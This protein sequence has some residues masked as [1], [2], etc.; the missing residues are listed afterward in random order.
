M[1]SLPYING[2]WHGKKRNDPFVLDSKEPDWSKFQEFLNGEV[3]YLS[4]KKAFPQEAQELFEEAEHMA[5]LRYK[6]Y[7][8]KT[9]EDWSDEVQ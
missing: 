9:R 8:R 7:L 3:R 4:V 5:K 1:G 2:L 6:S